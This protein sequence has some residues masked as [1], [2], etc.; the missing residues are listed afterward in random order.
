MTPKTLQANML[1]A[2]RKEESVEDMT[3]AEMAP[4]PTKDTATGVI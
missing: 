2:D 1:E 3:A 4:S